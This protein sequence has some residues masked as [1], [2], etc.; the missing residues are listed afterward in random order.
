MSARATDSASSF[1]SPGFDRSGRTAPVPSEAARLCQMIEVA[2]TEVPKTQV[3]SWAEFVPCM[4]V[5]MDL[6][7][8]IRDQIITAGK[9]TY[10][11]SA[12]VFTT[13]PVIV[14]NS[15]LLLKWIRPDRTVAPADGPTTSTSWIISDSPKSLRWDAVPFSFEGID[16]M[17]ALFHTQPEF[18]SLNP[19]WLLPSS[20]PDQFVPLKQHMAFLLAAA[21]IS[22]DVPYT[23]V[24]NSL[25]TI[26]GAAR[27]WN[28][29]PWPGSPSW[30]TLGTL[31]TQPI[32]DLPQPMPTLNITV[33]P[34]MISGAPPPQPITVAGRRVSSVYSR[35]ITSS[36]QCRECAQLAA[37]RVDYMPGFR[38]Y[39]EDLAAVLE[40][41]TSQ[42][43]G[44]RHFLA[45][46]HSPNLCP[47]HSDPTSL[48]YTDSPH[49]HHHT[50][51]AF[52]DRIHVLIVDMGD[53]VTMLMAKA[54]L[55]RCLVIEQG[56][57]R[58]QEVVNRM[59]EQENAL[60]DLMAGGRSSLSSLQD[61]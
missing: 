58:A 21:P 18:K 47:F 56:D 32:P 57:L 61:D 48:D 3:R 12:L 22:P 43:Q 59:K 46:C 45:C 49:H 60:R 10:M 29:R 4:Y 28:P 23:S 39:L 14:F 31:N 30:T 19:Q 44:Q 25:S 13:R 16:G 2:E 40:F 34:G 15:P 27:R 55:S 1:A 5:G 37:Q 11:P 36:W 7:L 50:R 33:H 24:I 38:I 35:S 52:P 26:L 9:I 42:Q 17:E 6:L 51:P 53:R 41:W 20:R 8:L 54:Q